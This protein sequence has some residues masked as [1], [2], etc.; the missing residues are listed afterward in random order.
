MYFKNVS[1]KGKE[2]KRI[3]RKKVDKIIS[4]P[5]KYKGLVI[6]MLPVK[7]NPHSM[8]MDFFELEIEDI[9]YMDSVDYNRYITECSYYNCNN[10]LG[11]YLKF[12]IEEV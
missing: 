7:A 1:Y 12:Y 4:N 10:E 5:S 2:L 6:Y 3:S 9:M 11:N 8:Y